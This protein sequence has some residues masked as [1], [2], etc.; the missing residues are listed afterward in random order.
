MGGQFGS[1][2]GDLAGM[3]EGFE[4]RKAGGN[5]QAQMGGAMG[6]AGGAMGVAGA[7]QSGV[8]KGKMG[9]QYKQA[10]LTAQGRKMQAQ[11]GLDTAA[12]V[13]S[14]AGPF[15]M[16]AGGVL[17]LISGLLNIKGKKAK[18]QER[19]ATTRRLAKAKHSS[20]RANAAAAGT[21]LAGGMLRTGAAIG[22]QPTVADPTGPTH[23]FQPTTTYRNG[24]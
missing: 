16:V 8:Q 23:T 10:G 6:I 5:M 13:A 9:K 21:Q 12:S 1:A 14:M 11:A 19:E 17:K 24:R 20:M 3:A 2:M 7:I 22:P 18:R 4:Q 15:G